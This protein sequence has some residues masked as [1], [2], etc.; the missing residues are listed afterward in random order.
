MTRDEQLWLAERNGAPIE[1]V[2]AHAME[3][4]RARKL[5]EAHAAARDAAFTRGLGGC[6]TWPR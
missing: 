2:R 4:H 3:L 6:G 1:H 5:A